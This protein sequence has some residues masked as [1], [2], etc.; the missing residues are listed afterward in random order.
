MYGRDA[1]RKWYC[2]QRDL[3]RLLSSPSGIAEIIKAMMVAIK[4]KVVHEWRNKYR[5]NKALG[6]LRRIFGTLRVQS[7]SENAESGAIKRGTRKSNGN[8]T[9]CLLGFISD[10]INTW[11]YHLVR[12]KGKFDRM[13]VKCSYSAWLKYKCLVFSK[14]AEESWG[15]KYGEEAMYGIEQNDAWQPKRKIVII[16]GRIWQPKRR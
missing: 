12:L 2:V 16:N 14:L 9:W 11:H 8:W 15:A 13:I 4:G 5:K 3:K 10:R 1:W 6:A 7:C